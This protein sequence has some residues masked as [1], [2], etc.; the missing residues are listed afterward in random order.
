MGLVVTCDD[1]A[2]IYSWIWVMKYDQINAFGSVEYD[3]VEPILLLL[4]NLG[5]GFFS[6]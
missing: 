5:Q 1:D 2:S 3:I 4:V 6:S